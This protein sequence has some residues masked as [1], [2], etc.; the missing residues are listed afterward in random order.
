MLT[1]LA[2]EAG[3]ADQ[4]RVVVVE[5]GSGVVIALADGAGGVASGAETAERVIA[6][7]RT[8]RPTTAHGCRSVLASLDLDDLGLTTAVLLY[9]TPERIVGASVGD[10]VVF[11]GD[12][13]L[14]A[15]QH[16]KPLLGSTMARIVPFE[17]HGPWLGTLVVASDGLSAYVPRDA[18]AAATALPDVQAV[19]DALVA[20]PRLPSGDLPDDVAVVVCRPG[21]S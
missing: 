19:A 14:T 3:S 20:L 16:R 9:A 10:S 17:R 1:A 2:V 21:T 4:D 12:D 18:I 8:K 15:D 5:R 11:L 13:E 6:A 7:A